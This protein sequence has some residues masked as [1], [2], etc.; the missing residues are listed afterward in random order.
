[1]RS[2]PG[3]PACVVRRARRW[4]GG[5]G[6]PCGPRRSS[7]GTGPSVCVFGGVFGGKVSVLW[8]YLVYFVVGFGGVCWFFGVGVW[9]VFCWR[10][11]SGTGPSVFVGV[12]GV[13]L[14]GCVWVH[15]ILLFLGFDI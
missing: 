4:R 12:F 7:S 10:S 14:V 9:G 8:V 5:R 1:M 11:S 6:G 15:Y 13:F 2:T 3:P